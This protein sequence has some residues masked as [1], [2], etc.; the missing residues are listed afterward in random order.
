M[1]DSSD[2]DAEGP[3][4]SAHVT[5]PRTV[6]QLWCRSY[7]CRYE[8]SH[9]TRARC[10]GC[11]VGNPEPVPA[12]GAAFDGDQP[13]GDLGPGEDLVQGHALGGGDEGVISPMQTERGRIVGRDVGD[14]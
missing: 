5:R 7:G 9:S 3:R 11:G 8:L 4:G 13:V 2:V 6:L 14:R 1:V 10:Q 12:V